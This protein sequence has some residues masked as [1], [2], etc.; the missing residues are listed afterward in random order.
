MNK[1]SLTLWSKEQVNSFVLAQLHAINFV[2]YIKKRLKENN[3]ISGEE[4]ERL[5]SMLQITSDNAKKR[6][7]GFNLDLVV[8][9]QEK[10]SEKIKYAHAKY[11]TIEKQGEDLQK[12]NIILSHYFP[13]NF[14]NYK[15]YMDYSTKYAEKVKNHK[16]EKQVS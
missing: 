1:P 4:L 16:K 2:A 15:E 13:V 8:G 12:K 11:D 5:Q 9:F 7:T 6:L 10:D 3:P 14:K